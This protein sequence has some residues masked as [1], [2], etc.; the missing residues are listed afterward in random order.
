MLLKPLTRRAPAGLQSMERSLR[1]ED[2]Q[3]QRANLVGHAC[4]NAGR[5]GHHQIDI[6]SQ[7]EARDR[8]QIVGSQPDRR[9]EE[10]RAAVAGVQDQIFYEIAVDQLPG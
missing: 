2:R 4:G 3:R 5:V 9:R 6:L 1:A 8:A 7:H 10:S